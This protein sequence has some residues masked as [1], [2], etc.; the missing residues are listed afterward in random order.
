[1]ID[2]FETLY[3]HYA[4]WGHTILSITKTRMTDVWISEV[5]AA[6]AAFIEGPELFV[7]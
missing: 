5:E 1:M 3:E 7:I 6:I 4:T 2:S